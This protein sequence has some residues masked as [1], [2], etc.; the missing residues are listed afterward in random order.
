[1]QKS[2]LNTEIWYLNNF[3]INNYDGCYYIS[4]HVVVYLYNS[5]SVTQVLKTRSF[6]LRW[7]E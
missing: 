5:V 4:N 3:K 2:K 7:A 1:M 6:Y